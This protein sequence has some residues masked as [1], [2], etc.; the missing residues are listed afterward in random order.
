M[1]NR[2]YEL[3]KPHFEE[4]RTIKNKLKEE[5]NDYADYDDAD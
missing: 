3:L 2:L 5:Y 1:N 4:L